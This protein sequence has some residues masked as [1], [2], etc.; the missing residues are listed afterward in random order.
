MLRRAGAF[1][2]P[3]AAAVAA[4]AAAFSRGRGRSYGTAAAGRHTGPEGTALPEVMHK[5]VGPEELKVR[6][7]GR[8]ILMQVPAVIE[9]SARSPAPARLNVYTLVVY[10]GCTAIHSAV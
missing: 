5:T 1:R 9:T 7:G 8:L 2:S 4:V 3:P 10:A 6:L